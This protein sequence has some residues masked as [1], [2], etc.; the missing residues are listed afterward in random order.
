M[1]ALGDAECSPTNS[2]EKTHISMFADINSTPGKTGPNALSPEN[3]ADGLL[4]GGNCVVLT[5]LIALSASGS[6]P[7]ES[8]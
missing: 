1:E 3:P 6:E 4:G 7:S 5:A 2:P 8:T